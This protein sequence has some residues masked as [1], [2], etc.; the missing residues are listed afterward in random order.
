MKESA[1]TRAQVIRS[2]ENKLEA[3]NAHGMD[4]GQVVTPGYA[5]PSDVAGFE[6]RDENDQTW[7]GNCARIE[8]GFYK[9]P[10][11]AGGNLVAI[12]AP[13]RRRHHRP[14]PDCITRASPSRGSRS[15]ARPARLYRCAP[16]ALDSTCVPDPVRVSA[17]EST[18]HVAAVLVAIGDTWTATEQLAACE[19]ARAALGELDPG[20]AG[21]RLA[22]FPRIVAA[23]GATRVGCDR[24]VLTVEHGQVPTV[25]VPSMA[26]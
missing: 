24:R 18:V 4:A 10:D 1:A 19:R 3:L 17:D 13:L 6:L 20:D 8:L 21:P 7:W 2:C 11:G 12:A 25:V 16:A 5:P 26:L 15:R 14:R 22:E 9:V 23:V